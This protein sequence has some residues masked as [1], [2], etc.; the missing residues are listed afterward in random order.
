MAMRGTVQFDSQANKLILKYS[1][2]YTKTGKYI[3]LTLAR[4]NSK[5][6]KLVLHTPPSFPCNIYVVLNISRNS[7]PISVGL[8]SSI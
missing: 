6:I 4:N 8:P 7:I 1:N 3:P 5:L 2:I